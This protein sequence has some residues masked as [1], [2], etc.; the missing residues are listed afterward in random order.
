[1]KPTA[2]PRRGA[3]GELTTPRG[4]PDPPPGHIYY[5]RDDGS[6]GI[7]PKAGYR[8]AAK[9][10]IEDV[11]GRLVASNRAHIESDHAGRK[12]T[13]K[14]QKDLE[15]LGY[16]FA[17]DGTVRRPRHH[18]EPGK[19]RMVPLEIDAEGRIQIGTGKESIGEMQARLRDALPK[20]ATKK[21]EK[22]ESAAWDTGE[23][24]V[25]IE[26][27]YDTGVTWNKVLTPAK[28]KELKLLLKKKGLADA[29][30]DR[31]VDGLVDKKGTIKVVL[32]TDPVR[33]AAPYTSLHA[34]EHG[35][36]KGKVEVHHGDPLY[37]GGGHDPVTLFGLKT[38]PH[39]ALHAFFD[40][41]TLPASSPI[42][43]VRLQPGVIQNKVKSVAKPAA[44]IVN[45]RTGAVTYE[46]LK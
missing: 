1:M 22:L 7:R 42:G 25:L 12:L 18:G 30:I 44:A 38:E 15:A 10:D 29:E 5:L 21:L 26:G 17:S 20:S 33:A 37:L 3:G 28:R 14:R 16:T 27:I 9:F 4:Y 13:P 36:P 31:L 24:V 34:A 46:P 39:D 32:G 19:P 2:V 23:K 43:P 11:D 35:T 8:G 41:L 40:D 45:P 6:F